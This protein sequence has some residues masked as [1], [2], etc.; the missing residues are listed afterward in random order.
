MEPPAGEPAL[1]DDRLVRLASAAS[2]GAALSSRLELYPRGM[3]A[4]RALKLGAGAL[5]GPKKLPPQMV[6][7]RIASR[8]PEAERLPGQ[9]QLD[10]MLAAEGLHLRWDPTEGALRLARPPGDAREH[11]DA[12]PRGRRPT[13]TWPP[14]VRPTPTPST[15]DSSGWTGGCWP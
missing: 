9:P 1:T 2:T 6:Q 15:T 8:Y 3:P 12:E 11:G 4:A 14:P 7:D 5:V 13:L 10:A